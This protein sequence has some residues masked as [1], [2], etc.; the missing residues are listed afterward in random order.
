MHGVFRF[1]S[2]RDLVHIHIGC[3]EKHAARC[4]GDD[5]DGVLESF[6]DKFRTVYGI[7]R[8]VHGQIS[9]PA[10]ADL[11]TDVEHGSF[12]HLSFADDD[13]AV[14]VEI[15][16]HA[17]HAFDGGSVHGVLIAASEIGRTANSGDFRYAHEI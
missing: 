2:R 5:G 8:D 7:D 16:E 12:V 9:F 15:V 13:D 11:F 6:G 10:S 4:D 1:R 3:V 17:A 14:D